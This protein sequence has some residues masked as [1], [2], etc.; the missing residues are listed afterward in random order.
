MKHLTGLFLGALLLLSSCGGGSGLDAK[1]DPNVFENS[2]ELQKIYDAALNAMGDQ[3]SKVDEVNLSV[4]NPADDGETGDAYLYVTVDYQDPDQP[5]QLL[6]QMFHGELGYWTGTQEVTITVNGSDEDRASF[7]LE[8][9]LFDFTSQVSAERMN[10]VVSAAVALFK[11]EHTDEF[12]YCYVER[13]DITFEGYRIDVSGKLAAN[14]QMIDEYYEFDFGG[15][16][17]D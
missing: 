2:E 16:R 11:E 1:V 3:A 17:I 14:D 7:R 6:R 15:S 13:I 5:K 12:A 10:K 8:D 9:Q 4:D